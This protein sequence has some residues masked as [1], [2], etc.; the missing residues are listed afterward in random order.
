M[1]M[2]FTRRWH[3][4]G[5]LPNGFPRITFKVEVRFL[6]KILSPLEVFTAVTADSLLV[7]G[8]NRG[9]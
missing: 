9:D 5:K 2:R 7:E 6:K 3:A 1:T 8:I 4:R